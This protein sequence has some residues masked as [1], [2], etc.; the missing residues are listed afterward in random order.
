MRFFHDAREAVFIGSRFS[1]LYTSVDCLAVVVRC[2]ELAHG[3][4]G[5]STPGVGCRGFIQNTSKQRGL[6]EEEETRGGGG[7]G[8][9]GTGEDE[10][11]KRKYPGTH[12][13]NES[14]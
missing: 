11:A 3:G 8:G 13:E 7:G 14:T 10:E 9:G 12:A 6:E 4:G 1:S 5:V 2:R